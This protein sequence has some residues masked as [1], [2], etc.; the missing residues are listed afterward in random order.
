MNSGPTFTSAMTI[1][2][3]R[4]VLPNGMTARL[5]ITA[6]MPK[7]RGDPVVELVDVGRSEILFEQELHGVGDGLAETAEEGREILL[8]TEEGDGKPTRFG[9]SRSW[10]SA[11][12]RRSA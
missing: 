9:P 11:L 3:P 10:I 6:P 1:G 12:T 2:T 7:R 5:M 8:R 4:K